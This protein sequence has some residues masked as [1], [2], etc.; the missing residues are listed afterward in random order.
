MI[1]LLAHY[2][3][4]MH[5]LASI[6]SPQKN[7]QQSNPAAK[8]N[9]ANLGSNTL[10][11]IPVGYTINGGVPSNSIYNGSVTSI[12]A[13]SFSFGNVSAPNGYYTICFFTQLAGDINPLNDT[14]CCEFYNGINSI[15]ELDNSSF[16]IFPNPLENNLIQI[17]NINGN[18][19][20]V[21][22]IDARGK[23]VYSSEHLHSE[24]LTINKKLAA[25]I[26]LV[27]ITNELKSY[28]KKLI[29]E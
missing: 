23:I 22:I 20:T 6:I 1:F 9:V 5:N 21:H 14:L 4:M 2:K 11:S 29:V 8:A 26:Y 10:L 13:D 19:L 28:C 25:G 16:A 24:S 7:V 12:Q 17:K 27:R 15:I 3:I 18:N